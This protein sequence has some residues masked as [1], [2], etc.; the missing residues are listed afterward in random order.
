MSIFYYHFLFVLK[1]ILLFEIILLVYNVAIP[2]IQ[3]NT[4]KNCSNQ[5]LQNRILIENYL[6]LNQKIY[7]EF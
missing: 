1:T 4:L 2:N 6:Q 5:K 3:L 7:I